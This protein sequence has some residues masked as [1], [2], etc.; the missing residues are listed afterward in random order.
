MT[1]FDK[2]F[3][4]ILGIAT[5]LIVLAIP[6][7]VRKVPRNPVYGYRTRAAM[8]SDDVWYAA[9]AYFAQRLIMASLCSAFLGWVVDMLRPFA[10]DTYLPVSVLII[11]MPPFIAAIATRRYVGSFSA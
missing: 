2:G 9:N 8:A 4:T 5:L 11:A 10:A 1:V 7:A 6:L 3:Y